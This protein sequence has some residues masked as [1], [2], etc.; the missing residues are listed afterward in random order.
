MN[1]ND[2]DGHT[3]RQSGGS[4]VKWFIVASVFVAIVI[5]VVTAVKL[6]SD[7]FAIV[8]A[9]SFCYFFV[10][11][12]LIGLVG[13]A[14][15]RFS[16]QSQQPEIHIHPGQTQQ[17]DG[18]RY[19]PPTR[20]LDLPSPNRGGRSQRHELPGAVTLSEISPEVQEQLEAAGWQRLS[21]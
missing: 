7:A 18:V 17:H 3:R 4:W 12:P 20:V 14:I 10:V 19:L 11:L 8:L 15:W 21:R 5:L 16:G 2:Y 9:L 1:Y 6:S 13:V